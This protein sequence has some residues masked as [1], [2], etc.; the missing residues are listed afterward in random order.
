[1][2]HTYESI[3]GIVQQFDAD[4]QL[5]PRS[6]QDIVVD[7]SI[8]QPVSANPASGTFVGGTTVT[9]STTTANAEIF[10]TVDGTDP[11]ENGVKYEAP[12]NITEN[13][14]LKAVVKTEDGQVSEVETFAYTITDSLQIHDIQGESHTSPFDNQTVEGI[15]GI[16]TYSFTLKRFDVLPYPNAGC[17]GR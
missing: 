4:Y 13:T 3:T 17:I 9:L 16:V 15:E 10:Y 12:I 2:E 8:V 11:I 5:I 7:S 1:M 6:Q 14:T